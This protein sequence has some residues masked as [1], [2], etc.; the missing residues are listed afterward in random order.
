MKYDD[1]INNP[2]M[3]AAS[4]DFVASLACL[5]GFGNFTKRI[6]DLMDCFLGLVAQSEINGQ[7]LDA[8]ISTI[9]T[10]YM[11]AKK[12]DETYKTLN[13]KLGG[14]DERDMERH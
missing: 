3:Q 11:H 7:D 9:S 1:I 8:P 4:V 14:C 12:I 2:E 10:I 5:C 6:A 13:A